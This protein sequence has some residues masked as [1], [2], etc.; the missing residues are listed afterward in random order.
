MA[1]VRVETLEDGRVV[2]FVL[3]RP[4]RGNALTAPLLAELAAAVVAA[5]ARGVRAAILTGAGERTFSTGYDVEA[6][7]GELAAGA[8]VAD[9]ESHP[10]ERALRAIDRS[11]IPFI[12]A[13]NGPATG[14]GFELAC[15]CDF[16][17]AVATARFAMP[18]ARL[19]LLYS[20]T[21]I[22]R[23]IDLVGVAM[24]KSL[25]LAALPVTAEEALG[26]RL[27]GRVV[28]DAAALEAEALTLA[29]RLAAN[30]PLAVAATKAVMNRHL[31][32][33]RLTPAEEREI[34]DLRARLFRSRDLAEGIAALLEKREPRF[35]GR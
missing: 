10:L 19:G 26:V 32:P 12:A 35:E 15:A 25:F 11:S 30:A 22:R 5:E 33:P 3:D 21:G 16:R 31:L 13:V 8:S 29:R 28:P 14:A 4:G 1:D 24:A 6:L 17:I 9:T 23:V 34:Q 2:R 18:P 20:H 27:V 7:A